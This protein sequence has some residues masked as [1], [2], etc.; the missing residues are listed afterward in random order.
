MVNHQIELGDPNGEVIE[1]TGGD[2]GVCNPIGRTTVSTNQT[3]PEL[4]GT[5]PPTKEYTWK[6]PWLSLHM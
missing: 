2:K 3:F 4:P 5:K 6:N 1:R